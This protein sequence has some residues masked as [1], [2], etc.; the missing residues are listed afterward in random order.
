MKTIKISYWVTTGLLCALYLFSAGMYFFNYEHVSS[1]FIKTGFPT[2]IIYPLA[3]LKL[4]AIVVWL[5][6][7]QSAIK[8]W[9]YSAAFFNMVLAFSAHISVSDGEQGAAVIGIVL[10]FSSYFLGKK[11]YNTVVLPE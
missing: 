3:I 6:Q 7:K 9:V 4:I 11:L 5:T 2:Y 10:L 8:E 1:E